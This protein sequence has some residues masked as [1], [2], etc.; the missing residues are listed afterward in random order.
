MSISSGQALTLT[1]WNTADCIET[2][3]GWSNIS[4]K[5]TF[6]YG[7][8]CRKEVPSLLFQIF[9][10]KIWFLPLKL[11]V[12][13]CS[14]Y[15]YCTTSFNYAWTQVLHRFK[16]CLQYAKDLPLW[17][18]LTMSWLEIRLINVPFLGQ[19]YHKNN[20]SFIIIITNWDCVHCLKVWFVDADLHSL[21]NIL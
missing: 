9:W 2:E 12:L 8:Y 13:W 20:S 5:S 4:E 15:H 19:S 6:Y 17:E 21:N 11:V 7:Q 14:G 1:N 10:V 16:S 3:S 18:S